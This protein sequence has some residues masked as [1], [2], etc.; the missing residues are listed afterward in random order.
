MLSISII[1][2][3]QRTLVVEGELIAP[4]VAELKSMCEP[5]RADLSRCGLIVDIRNLTLIIQEG[6][7]LLIDLMHEGITFRCSGVFA[8][9]VLREISRRACAQPQEARS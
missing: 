6:E 3:R 9:R 1:D 8:N 2:G 5:A 7:N 4:W